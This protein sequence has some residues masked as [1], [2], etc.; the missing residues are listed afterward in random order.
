MITIEQNKYEVIIV[1][2]GPA[3]TAAAIKLAQDNLSVLLIERANKPGGKNMFG[4][5]IY[6]EPTAKVIPNFW[7]DAPLERAIVSEELWLMDTTS[8]VKMGFT[9]LNFAQ[10]PYN[11]FSVIRSKFDNWF[12]QQAVKRGAQL[13]TNTTV[14]DL[15]YKQTGL[16]NKQVTGVQLQS[17]ATISA[18]VVLLA[19]GAQAKLTAKAGLRKDLSAQDFK[20][21]IKEELALAPEK[22]NSRFNLTEEQGTIIGMQGQPTSSLTGKGGL[23]TNKDSISL[24]LGVNLKQLTTK[25]LE[26]QQLMANFKAHPLIKRLIKGTELINYKSKTIPNGGYNKLPQL[27]DDG[28]LVAGD[29]AMLVSGRR[30]TD[31]AMLSGLYAAEVIAKARAANDFSS[32]ILQKY[33]TKIENS[34]F[35][36]D[37]KAAVSTANYYQQNPDVDFSISKSLNDASYKF[38]EINLKSNIEKIKTIKRESFDLQP[39]NKTATDLFHTLKDWSVY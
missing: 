21:Y 3:G 24:L 20:L 27:Y 39:F 23:W 6:R 32:N 2:A 28:L 29:A 33:E 37:M 5:A 15:V 13:L 38:F 26:M 7:E 16:L 17:G 19:E 14:I 30:G 11:K 25:N 9:G 8:A 36:E 35:I 4:G 12:A 18:D 31:L 1:G 22:I 34:F 10:P